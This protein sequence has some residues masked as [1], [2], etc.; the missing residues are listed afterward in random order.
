MQSDIWQCWLIC[1]VLA[2]RLA[3]CDPEALS[4]SIQAEGQEP[5]VPALSSKPDISGYLPP[6]VQ[7]IPS[8]LWSERRVSSCKL[9][10]SVP[11]EQ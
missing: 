3:A 11:R 10:F 8:H 5:A 4:P 1:V 7:Q 9:R 6:V 2:L